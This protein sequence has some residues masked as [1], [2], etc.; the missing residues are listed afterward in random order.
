M[1]G[2]VAKMYCPCANMF[3]VIDCD[4]LLDLWKTT[5]KNGE[6][7]LDVGSNIGTCSLLML[8]AGHK[9]SSLFFFFFFFFFFF[10]V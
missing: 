1:D 8:S 4:T 7:F 5:S 10:C 9:V 3:V 6:F 2:W